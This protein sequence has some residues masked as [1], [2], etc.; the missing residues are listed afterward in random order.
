M[1]S[2]ALVRI[3]SRVFSSSAASTSSQLLRIRCA[4]LLQGRGGQ[5]LKKP[6]GPER[7]SSTVARRVRDSKSAVGEG[8]KAGPAERLSSQQRV[9][10]ERRPPHR[11]SAARRSAELS[12]AQGRGRPRPIGRP[13][14]LRL[15][16]ERRDRSWSGN[17]SVVFR[18]RQLAS[19][20]PDSALNG[21]NMQDKDQRLFRFI[22]VGF[23]EAWSFLKILL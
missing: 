21:R 10:H 14:A 5:F 17:V 7:H 19:A 15:R 23:D 11:S 2:C 13:F 22:W 1:M 18:P 12:P 4:S 20:C 9:A 8:F 6:L 3:C 16:S